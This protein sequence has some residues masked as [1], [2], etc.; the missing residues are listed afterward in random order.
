MSTTGTSAARSDSPT[1]SPAQ[2]RAAARARS[3]FARALA[4]MAKAAPSPPNMK[5]K[6]A[7][8]SALNTAAM[9]DAPTTL[10][11]L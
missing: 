5:G 7:P 11:A 4:G 3:A 6:D 10:T 1:S 9:V 8:S 2:R